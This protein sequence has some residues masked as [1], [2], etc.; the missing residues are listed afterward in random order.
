[1]AVE[2]KKLEEGMIIDG[3]YFRYD[4]IGRLASAKKMS[5][6]STWFSENH[7][8]VSMASNSYRYSKSREVNPLIVI[9]DTF[10]DIIDEECISQAANSVTTSGYIW[11]S[12]SSSFMWSFDVKG[13]PD[14]YPNFKTSIEHIQEILEH[15]YTLERGAV[16]HQLF[17]IL[18][19]NIFT[20]FES[21]ISMAFIHKLLGSSDTIH[22]FLTKQTEFGI[23]QPKMTDLLCD[24]EHIGDLIEDMKSKLKTDLTK[25]S[26]HDTDKVA[27]R[28]SQIGIRV[29]FTRTGIN[30]IVDTRN[31]IVHRN[32]RTVNGD[33]VVV[34][35]G[36]LES[37]I[38]TVSM[39]ADHIHGAPAFQYED[40]QEYYLS[41]E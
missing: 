31:D 36:E 20:T 25:A 40:P 13:E 3:T 32:G 9:R 22:H 19:A 17:H 21:Y 33:Q 24:E 8:V 38:N 26:W 10:A 6:M 7:S 2:I 15:S 41:H 39:I 12:A 11:C 35:R 1:M 16:Q 30:K 23:V 5:L 29:P 14:P 37:A 4:E 34:M 28:F 27:R 18:Y